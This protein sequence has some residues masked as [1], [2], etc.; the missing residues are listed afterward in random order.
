MYKLCFFVPPSHLEDVK[1]ALFA[2]GAGKIGLYD[3]CCWQTLGIGQFKP[4]SGSQPFIGESDQLEQ[5]DEWKVEMVCDDTLI[6][7]IVD[8]LKRVHP[9][10]EVAYDVWQLAEF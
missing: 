8:E 9:Y 3:A 5:L 2:K 6:R 1:N 4:M 7:A 10:E